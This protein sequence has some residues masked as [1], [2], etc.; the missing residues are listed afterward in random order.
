MT[1]RHIVAQQH[2]N[3]VAAD[4]GLGKMQLARRIKRDGIAACVAGREMLRP[5]DFRKLRRRVR[6]GLA[7]LRHGHPAD[8]PGVAFKLLVDLL[9]DARPFGPAAIGT[10][11][12]AARVEAP[13]Q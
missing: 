4:V 1:V 3:M 7:H 12:E 10:R 5:V 9:I 2:D 11:G 6:I 13:I 8:H